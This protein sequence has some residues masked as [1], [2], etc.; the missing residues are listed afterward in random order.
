MNTLVGC[1]IFDSN[2]LTSAPEE[3]N[4]DELNQYV[5]EW[6]EAKPKVE[7]LSAL[8]YD[9]ALIIKE[10]GKLSTLK[11]LPP[12]YANQQETDLIQAEYESYGIVEPQK[13]GKAPEEEAT[14]GEVIR[15]T[16]AAHLAFFMREDSA[17]FG[18]SVL[19]KRYPEIF[20]NL[21][22]VVKKIT[23]EEQTIYSLRVGPFNKEAS[24]EKLCFLLS[25]HKYQCELSDF[26][27]NTI[28]I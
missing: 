23:R 24:A 19:K 21:T 22:P 27:G 14:N 7:R 2:D 17:R 3:L 8:E 11:N 15:Q 6:E 4:Y 12:Q 25:Y 13:D 1:S 10:V 16:Y 28:S 5:K 9:L 18:W 26:S 20:S